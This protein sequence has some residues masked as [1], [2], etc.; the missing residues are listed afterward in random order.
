MSVNHVNFVHYEIDD[1]Y[2]DHARVVHYVVRALC[3]KSVPPVPSVP[4]VLPVLSISYDING[5]YGKYRIDSN[6]GLDQ[7]SLLRREQ[8]EV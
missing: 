2:A 5:S 6:Y 1:H 7:P 4:S 8:N 3:V